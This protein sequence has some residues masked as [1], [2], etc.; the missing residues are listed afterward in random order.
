MSDPLKLGVFGSI[1]SAS[2]EAQIAKLES[3]LSKSVTELGGTANVSTEASAGGAKPEVVGIAGALLSAIK[4]DA[5]SPGVAKPTAAQKLIFYVLVAITFGI[6]ALMVNR[7]VGGVVAAV[8][9]GDLEK[10]KTALKDA[11]GDTDGE[12]IA[13]SPYITNAA[14][15]ARAVSAA[16]SACDAINVAFDI[17]AAKSQKTGADEDKKAP[18]PTKASELLVG[19]LCGKADKLSALAEAID[20]ANDANAL[21]KALNDNL[22]TNETQTFKI[23]A[24]GSAPSGDGF[25]KLKNT[26]L[27]LAKLIGASSAFAV[28]L[29]LTASR[30]AAAV[31][32]LANEAWRDKTGKKSANEYYATVALTDDAT[33]KGTVDTAAA[34]VAAALKALVNKTGSDGTNKLKGKIAVVADSSAAVDEDGIVGDKLAE[35][36]GE[37]V[38]KA[39]E[40]HLSEGGKLEDLSVAV[41]T[42]ALELLPVLGLAKLDSNV[43][44]TDATT[45]ESVGLGGEVTGKIKVLADKYVAMLKAANVGETNKTLGQLIEEEVTKAKTNAE[46]TATAARAAF[47]GAVTPAKIPPSDPKAPKKPAEDT[48]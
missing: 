4:A 31:K 44:I 41:P 15:N 27:S 45:A 1:K 47:I 32:V 28:A 30:K 9:G 8:Q 20:K 26:T 6:L 39:A 23:K 3:N 36:V 5:S 12:K 17:E 29:D 25:T 38:C 13:Q 10:V 19:L 7:A 43:D 21:V 11:F 24:G 40:K 48:K 42:K 34:E 35:G 16:A 18:V 46:A 22:A 14:A 37:F 2:I 33:L